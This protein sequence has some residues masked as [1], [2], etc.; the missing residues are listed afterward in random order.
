MS[1][2]DRGW[3]MD[4]VDQ[5]REHSMRIV[6]DRIRNDFCL[7]F[8]VPHELAEVKRWTSADNPKEHWCVGVL[9]DNPAPGVTGYGQIPEAIFRYEPDREQTFD[10]PWSVR[11]RPASVLRGEFTWIRVSC[12]ADVQRYLQ[13]DYVLDCREW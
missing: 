1:T 13:K 9:N 8:N 5:T 2:H 11:M 10:G 6:A 4:M 7:R 12:L 3:F